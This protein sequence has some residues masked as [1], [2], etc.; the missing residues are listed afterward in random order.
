LRSGPRH[1]G[2]SD[3]PLGTVF[4]AVVEFAVSDDDA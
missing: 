2:Q 3:G 1:C 4:G